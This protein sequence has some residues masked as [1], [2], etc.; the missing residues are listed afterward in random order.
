MVAIIRGA[1]SSTSSWGYSPGVVIVFIGVNNTVTWRNDD[2]VV[3]T[4]SSGTEG[5][6]SSMDLRPGESYTFTFATPGTYIYTCVYH[7]WM[8]GTVIVRGTP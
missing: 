2:T 7:R 6:S 4:V 5:F 3:H 8:N 1:A